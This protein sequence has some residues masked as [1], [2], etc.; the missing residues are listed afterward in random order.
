MTLTRYTCWHGGASQGATQQF[1][2]SPATRGRLTYTARCNLTPPHP[3]THA[4]IHSSG[5]SYPPP[6]L[7]LSALHLSPTHH[8]IRS[9]TTPPPPWRRGPSYTTPWR[10][11]T[12]PTTYRSPRVQGTRSSAG[13]MVLL[14]QSGFR[15]R[16]RLYAIG[17]H[18]C[19]LEVSIRSIQQFA[20][21]SHLSPMLSC[22][23]RRNTEGS[24]W[25]PQPTGW[26]GH[27]RCC[28]WCHGPIIAGPTSS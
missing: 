3:P 11:S 2:W 8:M 6:P 20:S 21:R 12:G 15:T 25:P 28:R 4:M 27:G 16:V 17:S 23:P 24:P 22:N 26:G 19:W 1:C 18:D 7:Y 13:C 5:D 14:F 10:R 9:Y